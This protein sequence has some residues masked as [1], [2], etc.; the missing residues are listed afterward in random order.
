M[1][2]LV[3]LDVQF[4]HEPPAFFVVVVDQPGELFGSTADGLLRGL[5]EIVTNPPIRQRPVDLG[6]EA[7]DDPGWRA[8]WHENAEPLVEYY[9]LGASFLIG[10]HL[11][12][13]LRTR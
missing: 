1:A 7:R 8:S 9:P 2:G 3:R 12:Q 6:V 5:Q 11:R 10:R 4:P 13:A